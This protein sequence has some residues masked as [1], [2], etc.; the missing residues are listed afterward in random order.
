MKN[1]KQI[2]AYYDMVP[3]DAVERAFEVNPEGKKGGGTW[4]SMEVKPTEPGLYAVAKFEG[5]KMVEFCP[6]WACYDGHFGPNRAGYWG[7]LDMTHWM[8]HEDYFR[9][10]ESLKK[11]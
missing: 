3:K 2:P 8:S 1:E 10:L 5:D 7:S 6:D 9:A 11:E 4:H